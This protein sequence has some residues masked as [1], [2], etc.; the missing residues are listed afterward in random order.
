MLRVAISYGTLSSVQLS[1]LADISD[2]Y[3]LDY[4]HVTTR[5]NIQFNSINKASN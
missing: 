2:R 4:R 3:E 5:Q 1:E